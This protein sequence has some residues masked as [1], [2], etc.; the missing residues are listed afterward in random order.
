MG[1]NGPTNSDVVDNAVHPAPAPW[2]CR[3]GSVGALQEHRLDAFD[4]AT[5]ARAR[6]SLLAN[7]VSRACMPQLCALAA[8][9][10]AAGRS[11]AA[12]AA[13]SWCLRLGRCPRRSPT[14]GRRG[15]AWAASRR[16]AAASGPRTRASHAPSRPCLLLT[17]A[18]CALSGTSARVVE[19][20]GVVSSTPRVPGVATAAAD[21]AA[22][23]S[24]APLGR[25]RPLAGGARD[26]LLLLLS[27]CMPVTYM[28][29]PW[30]LGGG[31]RRVGG[32]H[33]VAHGHA[34]PGCSGG[35]DRGALS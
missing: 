4:E 1:S 22:A 20:A 28:S 8:V 25:A 13:G 30:R 32:V 31:S 24:A 2:I 26:A 21:A 23:L 3:R 15:R 16:C 12:R 17:P 6:P 7:F 10:S 35:V 11:R 18:V 19:P 34:G 9:L 27:A 29:S 14:G 5:K 33:A